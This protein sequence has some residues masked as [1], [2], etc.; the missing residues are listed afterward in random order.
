MFTYNDTLADVLD[1]QVG[2][3]VPTRWPALGGFK[4]IPA[5]LGSR[6]FLIA[7]IR[8]LSYFTNSFPT[9][10]RMRLNAAGTRP[11]SAAAVC[12]SECESESARV[13]E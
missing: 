1:V 8:S 13:R 2:R 9:S 12:E 5:A 3:L 10:P 7:R 11:G 6:G 4:A